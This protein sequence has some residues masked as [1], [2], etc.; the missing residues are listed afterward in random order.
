MAVAPTQRHTCGGQR[1]E[2]P[3]ELPVRLA[4][5]F[6]K[7][8][9]NGYRRTGTANRTPRI[10]GD[11]DAV[12]VILPHHLDPVGRASRTR[13]V[14]PFESHYS[15]ER[16]YPVIRHSFALS[17]RRGLEDRTGMLGGEE[18]IEREQARS[19]NVGEREAEYIEES[20]GQFHRAALG[21]HIEMQIS[22]PVC[23]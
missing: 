8:P 19:G 9:R 12:V 22:T 1:P 15:P 23:S 16:V 20:R 10:D 7:E 6:C 11:M 2:R 13:R 21:L 14:L 5:I 17:S 3:C 4:E 18:N